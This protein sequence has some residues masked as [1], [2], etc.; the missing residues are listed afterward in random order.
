M[1]KSKRRTLRER[2]DDYANRIVKDEHFI[3]SVTGISPSATLANAVFW[4][5]MVAGRAAQRDRR[6]G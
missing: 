3:R 4:G 6:R 5:Y 2:A 1:S